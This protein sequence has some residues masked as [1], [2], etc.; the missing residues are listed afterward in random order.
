VREHKF[1][2][3]RIDNGEWVFGAY[4]CLH[5]NDG[6]EHLHHFIIPDNA[7]IP[8]DMP[9]GLIQVEVDP[10]T[11][12]QF[13]GL[14][15]KNGKEIYEGDFLLCSCR[16]EGFI[17]VVEFGN[18]NCTYSWGW[19][20]RKICGENFNTDILLWVETET[21]DATCEIIGNIYEAETEEK[22]C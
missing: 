4:F 22:S 19:Q 1:R 2:G 8:K 16:E 13:T 10:D 21:D 18:P 12:G 11:I 9:I 5:H 3:K 6:R 17:A 20:L 7:D 14:H 15:D